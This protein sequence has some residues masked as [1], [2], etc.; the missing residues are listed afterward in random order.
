[1]AECEMMKN[2]FKAKSHSAHVIY[3]FFSE[4]GLLY[5]GCLVSLQ[6]RYCHREAA[7]QLF[8]DKQLLILSIFFPFY[9]LKDYVLQLLDDSSRL[10]III[11]LKVLD[12]VASG[13]TVWFFL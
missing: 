2:T 9:R 8:L 3:L 1:M 7:A 11:S 4:Q 10:A 12:Q 13:F 5:L 6:K